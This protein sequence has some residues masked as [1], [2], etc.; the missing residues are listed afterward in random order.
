MLY[1]LDRSQHL[2][3]MDDYMS[4]FF[5]SPNVIPSNCS[6]S[7]NRGQISN[8]GPME[9][10]NSKGST[11]ALLGERLRNNLTAEK[12]KHED[13]GLQNGG[14]PEAKSQKL[15]TIDDV[16]GFGTSKSNGFGLEGNGTGQKHPGILEQVLMEKKTT[17]VNNNIIHGSNHG[18]RTGFNMSGD[19]V[20]PMNQSDEMGRAMAYSNV[21]SNRLRKG[22]N[23]GYPNN[24]VNS[25]HGGTMMSSNGQ[26]YLDSSAM[27]NGGVNNWKSRP[28]HP[29]RPQNFQNGTPLA[30]Q[31]GN[32]SFGPQEP[33]GMFQDQQ[34]HLW[35][36]GQELPP[37]NQYNGGL[38]NRG[39]QALQQQ[40][41]PPPYQRSP[42]RMMGRSPVVPQQQM[43]PM[44]YPSSSGG[45]DFVNGGTRPFSQN[46]GNMYGPN[47]TNDFMARGNG[48]TM[49]YVNGPMISPDHGTGS[50]M[51]VSNGPSS[52]MSYDNSPVMMTNGPI[53]RSQPRYQ[54]EL[55]QTR[56][57]ARSNSL[58]SPSTR[59]PQGSPNLM[60]SD[61]SSMGGIHNGNDQ[62]YNGTGILTGNDCYPPTSM[63]SSLEDTN[64]SRVH[65]DTHNL[66]QNHQN[67]PQVPVVSS[68]W[69]S[70]SQEFRNNFLQ[71][72]HGALKN[73]NDPHLLQMA[74]EA[75]RLAFDQCDTQDAYQMQLA[76]W[77]ASIFTQLD[78]D[79]HSNHDR[80]TEHES[81]VEINTDTSAQSSL[82]YNFNPSETALSGR[83]QSSYS[84][85]SS[86]QSSS[87]CDKNPLLATLLP[88]NSTSHEDEDTN[89][90]HLQNGQGVRED[91]AD[92]LSPLMAPQSSESGVT[93]PDPKAFSSP[94][95]M[96]P[97]STTMTMSANTPSS[98]SNSYSMV[99][100]SMN[101]FPT[102]ANEE[103]K[104]NSRS[105]LTGRRLSSKG[106]SNN[107]QLNNPHSVDSGI[108]IG[109]P[110]SVPSNSSPKIQMGTSPSLTAV[111][112]EGP[113]DK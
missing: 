85:P 5:D 36:N 72:L 25:M 96:S 97:C 16:L 77:L 95:S 33:M 22:P 59:L 38:D 35:S 12:R 9:T 105:G 3:I 47:G 7:I 100:S 73:F 66:S 11:K 89:D 104:A 62:S 106:G 34:H 20:I 102:P 90:D 32:N 92:S 40:P 71:R 111:A 99:S 103:P 81:S 6:N 57:G 110:R 27:M 65:Y 42:M 29:G 15:D 4:D 108:G 94:S 45:S 70:T 51:A 63:G 113:L 87:L 101:G 86:Q 26:E 8:R 93:S 43:S 44:G 49:S 17:L 50:M 78:S 39:Q 21:P 98:T 55:A 54:H 79:T 1:L 13:Y 14:M 74:D 109:S 112:S 2:S 18:G 83:E 31:Y 52:Y 10:L 23:N 46:R 69:K 64:Q 80:A 48:G 37:S 41:P 24:Q 82:Q 88:G 84:S 68:S 76:E 107:S 56:I 60:A 58:H 28:V 19:Q 30:M 53:Q 75:E 61:H 67:S 91:V